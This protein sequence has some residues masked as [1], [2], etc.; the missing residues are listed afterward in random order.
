MVVL[1]LTPENT[2]CF[3]GYYDKKQLSYDKKYFLF[4]KV[5]FQNRDPQ[6]NDKAEIWIGEIKT[7]KYQKLD[8]TYS[9]NFQQGCMISWLSDQEIIYNVRIE[10]EFFSKIYNIEDGKSKIVDSPISCIY[11]E[12]KIALS[13]NFSRL[14]K[15]RPGYGYVGVEDKYEK[16]KWPEN[17]GIYF[18]DI[19]KN[20]KKLI[21]PLAKML[22][23]RKEK[24]INQSYGW[25]NHTLFNKD[26]TR[27]CFVNRWKAKFDEPFK[28]RFIT[29]DLEGKEIY[30][31][32]DSYLISHFD[33]KDEKEII[34]WSE[35]KGEK[36]FWIVED[37]TG[38]IKKLS[39]KIQK[40][41]GHCSYSKNKRFILY[42]TY[43]IENYRY[44]KIFNIE[45][46]EEV[47][48]GKFYSSPEITGSI[49]CDL[50]PRWESEDIITFDSIHENYR[51]SYLLKLNLPF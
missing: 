28:T 6:E 23:F 50:H 7:K 8:E 22:E 34:V 47:I 14:A 17:D 36:G 51:R 9:W 2:I 49:R 3:F 41:D 21:I 16:E 29:S 26:G 44:L 20:N 43:P 11:P 32:I 15:W 45:R 13:L 37:K 27:F 33:W 5:A 48:I 35:I 10:K 39:E 42:D 40:I 46:D 18:V 1:P 38:K 25:F 4:L 24:G 12:K 19:E 31:L 30:D